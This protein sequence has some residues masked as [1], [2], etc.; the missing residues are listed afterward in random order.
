[1]SLTPFLAEFATARRTATPLLAV[2]TQDQAATMRTLEGTLDAEDTPPCFQW[3]FMGGLRARNLA[4]VRALD[5]LL[6]APPPDKSGRPVETPTSLAAK[7]VRPGDLLQLLISQ[8]PPRKDP[9]TKQLIPTYQLPD[10]SLVF[11]GNAHRFLDNR[12]DGASIAVSQGI[13]NL[14]DVFKQTGS[15]LIL[16]GPSF[17][18]PTELGQD[19]LVLDEPMP[20]T[21]MLAA[22]VTTAHEITGVTPPDA[23]GM[24]KAT[25]ILSTLS[26]FAAEQA[27]SISLTRKGLNLQTLWNRKRTIINTT[28]GLTVD[29]GDDLVPPGGLEGILDYTDGLANGPYPPLVIVLIDE[30]D[31]AMAGTGAQGPGDTSGVSQYI[32]GTLLQALED[33]AWPGMWAMGAPGTGKT[34]VARMMGKRLGAIT[35]RLDMGALRGGLVGESER[36]TRTAIKTILTLGGKRRVLFIGTSNA[37]GNLSAQLVRRFTRRGKWYFPL[38][39]AEERQ[40]IWP[41]QLAAYGLQEPS[42]AEGWPD[43]EGWTGAEIR[44][45]C[46]YAQASGRSVLQAAQTI[47]PISQS[48]PDV[49]ERL[50]Q[51]AIGKFLNAATGRPYQGRGSDNG[52]DQSFTGTQSSRKI[53]L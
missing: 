38:P 24:A 36:N 20:D 43:D 10:D 39:T 53:R 11:M 17:T 27:I 29:D 4:A 1:M 13:G 30:I 49:I 16:L 37:G 46:E 6:P 23:A 7:M 22:L 48:H 26:A 21:E 33:Y 15:T 19:I 28:P 8:G 41:I 3:D 34:L 42:G 12:P 25:Q 9:E 18:I 32:H 44:N 31:D 5:T 35:L 2:Q 50:E 52:T 45:C 40:E 47:I 14:R 51:Q